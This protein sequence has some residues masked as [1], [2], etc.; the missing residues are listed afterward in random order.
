MLR[1]LV[2]LRRLFKYFTENKTLILSILFVCSIIK[3]SLWYALFGVNILLYSSIQDI[4][5]SFADYF[6]SII[7]LCISYILCLFVRG[8]RNSILNYIFSAIVLILSFLLFNIL[9][10]MVISLLFFFFVLAIL[11]EFYIKKKKALLFGNILLLLLLFTLVQPLEQ[12]IFLGPSKT[13]TDNSYQTT[14]FIE[15]SASYDLFSF[16][17]SNMTIHTDSKQYYY[18]GG[19]SNYYFI[20]NHINDEVLIIPKSECS[21]IKGSPI[22]IE[23]ILKMYD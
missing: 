7:Y 15:R 13:D 19:N 1:T 2:F 14:T 21:N 16:E 10:R 3:T 20:L 4:F 6:M 8:N 22:S 5:I 12:F 9:F 23:K 18:I 17:Y 11:S